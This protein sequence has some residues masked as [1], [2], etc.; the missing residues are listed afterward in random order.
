MRGRRR[1]KV[2]RVGEV[3]A[4]LEGKGRGR[5]CGRWADFLV[6]GM[7]RMDG[8]DGAAGC[9]ARATNCTPFSHYLYFSTLATCR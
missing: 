3:R 2:G 8:M 6:N 4:G 5:G 7:D 1:S 9:V